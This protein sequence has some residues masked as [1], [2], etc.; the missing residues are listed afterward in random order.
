MIKLFLFAKKVKAPFTK[1]AH[2]ENEPHKHTFTS[3]NF[4]MT[5]YCLS[6]V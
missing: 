5:W 6:R 2:N 1:R 4:K 3:G